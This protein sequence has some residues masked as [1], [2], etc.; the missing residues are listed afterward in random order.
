MDT[1]KERLA[2][3]RQRERLSTRE[4][5]RHVSASHGTVGNYEPGGR[6]EKVDAEY[7]AEVCRAFGISPRWLLLG[8]GEM[9]DRAPTD[10]EARLAEIRRVLREGHD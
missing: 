10:A 7:L 1:I 8:E 9:R 5:A 3:V 2:E 4:F 6:S